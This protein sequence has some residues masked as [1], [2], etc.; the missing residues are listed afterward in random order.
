[1]ARGEA[2]ELLGLYPSTDF[3]RLCD[4][5]ELVQLQAFADLLTS[6]RL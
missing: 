1:M 4:A 5:G 6:A 3:L 2:A